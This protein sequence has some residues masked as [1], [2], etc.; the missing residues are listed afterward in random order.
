MASAKYN[1]D[2]SFYQMARILRGPIDAVGAYAS[3]R[4]IAEARGG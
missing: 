1:S 4:M 2:E 3:A